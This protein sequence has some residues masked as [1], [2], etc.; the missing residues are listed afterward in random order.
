MGS[1]FDAKTVTARLPTLRFRGKVTPKRLLW[2]AGFWA[3]VK[4][5]GSTLVPCGVPTRPRNP[6]PINWGSR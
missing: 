5:I 3:V 1:P 6:S 4:L 2:Q